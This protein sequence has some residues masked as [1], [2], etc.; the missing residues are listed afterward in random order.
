M[1][2]QKNSTIYETLK[3]SKNVNKSYENIQRKKT[4]Q[5]LQIR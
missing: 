4:R 3:Q 2:K 1:T 5:K